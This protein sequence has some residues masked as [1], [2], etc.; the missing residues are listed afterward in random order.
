MHAAFGD[1]PPDKN[2]ILPQV[3]EPLLRDGRTAGR[4]NF[5]MSLP[6]TVQASHLY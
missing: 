5:R 6:A 4:S 1:W 2:T 3:G